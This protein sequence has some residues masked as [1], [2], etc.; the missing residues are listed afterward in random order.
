MQAAESNLGIFFSFPSKF[1]WVYF[2]IKRRKKCSK[3]SNAI[4]NKLRLVM[5]SDHFIFVCITNFHD[6]KLTTVPTTPQL[7]TTVIFFLLLFFSCSQVL[8]LNIPKRIFVCLFK[9]A[10]LPSSSRSVDSAK[11]RTLKVTGSTLLQGSLVTIFCYSSI[12]WW[13]NPQPKQFIKVILPN[14]VSAFLPKNIGE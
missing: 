10:S 12:L 11:Q 6:K 9:H 14:A 4:R 5:Y 1:L 7:Y 8:S 2:K 13:L 3:D